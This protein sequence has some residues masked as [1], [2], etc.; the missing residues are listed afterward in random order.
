MH[1]VFFLL[2]I[3]SSQASGK[4]LVAI[5]DDCPEGKVCAKYNNQGNSQCFDI[6]QVAPIIF[7]L[8]FD[9]KSP[10]VCAQSGRFST[11][12]HIFRN[13]LYAID[14]AT[15][16]KKSAGTIHASADGKAFV[17]DKCKDPEGNNEQTKTDGCGEGYG[18]HVRILHEG[19][20]M[21]LYAHLS[22]VFVKNGEIVKRHQKLGTEGATGMA[23]YRHLHWDVH[24]LEGNEANWEK[25]MSNP[26]WGGYSV[27]YKFT[28]RINNSEKVINSREIAC[29]WLDMSQPEWTGIY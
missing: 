12:S 29:R 19:G 11:A 21:S 15:P 22:K 27:P 28:I 7:D 24:K 20:Y 10:V 8:P 18:N 6:P 2:L 9:K 16:Y 17:F 3:I 4:C 23:A 5:P 25:I 14:L 13:M 1:K 26:G